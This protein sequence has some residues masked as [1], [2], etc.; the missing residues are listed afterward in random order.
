LTLGPGPVISTEVS[1][2]SLAARFAAFRRDVAMVR[3]G[4]AGRHPA[5][6]TVPPLPVLPEPSDTRERT[7]SALSARALRVER[8]V[9]ETEDAVTLVLRDPRGAPIPFAAGQFFTV[10]LTID[11]EHVRRAYSAS[12]SPLEPETAAITI[13]RVPG[14]KASSWLNDQAREGMTLE[15]LGPSGS[16]VV[17]PAPEPR[18]SRELVLVAGGSGVT[19]MMAIVRATLATEAGARITL[20]YGNRAERDVIFAEDLARLARAHEGRLDVR[21]VFGT[22]FDCGAL[23]DRGDAEWFVCG[24]EPMMVAVKAALLGRGVLA[25]RIH[26]ER[27]LQP[28]LRKAAAPTRAEAHPV[29]LRRSG[30]ER[31]FVVAPGQTLLEAGLDAKASMD[32]SCAM[33]GCAACKVKLVSGEVVMEE[34]NCLTAEE[35]EEGYVLACVGRPRGPVTLEAV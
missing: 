27:F 18:A 13:K 24:P 35:R 1:T 17:P 20:V 8:V 12:S 23:P 28:H 6:F 30:S 15:V 11:G 25:A 5:P 31:A 7:A 19:P 26:E 16:F 29:V 3:D 2:T 21:H 34:P 22:V 33:G 9:R 32:F 14:G 4:L 10:L